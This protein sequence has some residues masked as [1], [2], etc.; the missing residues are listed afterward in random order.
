M[1]EPLL[2][3]GYFS[4]QSHPLLAPLVPRIKDTLREY[5]LASNGRLQ[6]EFVDP[7]TDP[8]NGAGGES[9]PWHTPDALASLMTA[10]ACL[11]GQCV[12]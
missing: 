6:L 1:Q 9:D 7:L 8:E 12:F 10:A 2:I 5:E 4:E 3:R 11:T